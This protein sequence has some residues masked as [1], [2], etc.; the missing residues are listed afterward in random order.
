MFSTL[1]V[2]D[3]RD[4]SHWAGTRVI[5][6]WGSP[7]KLAFLCLEKLRLGLNCTCKIL[8]VDGLESDINIPPHYRVIHQ[9]NLH[10]FTGT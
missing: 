9:T 4:K 7:N 8:Y 1:T 5:T 2:Q 10:Q 3:L 6:T